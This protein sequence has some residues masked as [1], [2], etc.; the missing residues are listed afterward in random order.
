MRPNTFF[1]NIIRAR[2]FLA[3]CLRKRGIDVTM[4]LS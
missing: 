3:E 2:N 1:Q 4:E